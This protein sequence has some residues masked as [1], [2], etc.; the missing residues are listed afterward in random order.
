MFGCLSFLSSRT[1]RRELLGKP[2]FS[3]WM[4]TSGRGR[5]G[6][7]RASSPPPWKHPACRTSPEPRGLPYPQEAS[8]SNSVLALHPPFVLPPRS[9]AYPVPPPVPSPPTPGPSSAPL[10]GR[11]SASAPRGR[12][13]P[14]RG[15]YQRAWGITALGGSSARVWGS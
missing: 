15:G 9:S 13:Q 11:T 3:A 8:R 6:Q 2:S 5:T 14:G 10:S 4:R 12:R 1:S 7:K